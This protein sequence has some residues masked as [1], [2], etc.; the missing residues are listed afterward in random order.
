MPDDRFT[1]ADFIDLNISKISTLV[2]I[3]QCLYT[4]KFLTSHIWSKEGIGKQLETK[5]K[6][7]QISIIKKT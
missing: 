2:K 3:N 5:S 6:E 1:D 4:S 7:H